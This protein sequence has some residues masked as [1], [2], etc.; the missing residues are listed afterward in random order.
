MTP[1]KRF[2]TMRPRPISYHKP[3]SLDQAIGLLDAKSVVLNGGQ[4]LLATLRMR[5]YNPDALVDIKHVPGL[6]AEV[7]VT[8]QSME[9]GPRVT[10]ENFLKTPDIRERMPILYQAGQ[11]LADAQIRAQ[12]TV[13]GSMCWADPRANYPVAMLACDAVIH[14]QGKGG[15]RTIAADEFFLGFRANSLRQEVVT[16]VTVPG[17]GRLGFSTYREYSRQSND[18]CIVNV[19]VAEIDGKFRVAVGGV[20][21]RP[22]LV[23]E[24]AELLTQKAGSASAAKFM[25]ILDGKGL[26]PVED[27]HGAPEF[28]FNLV[29]EMLAEIAVDVSGGR[30]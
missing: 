26:S 2:L 15:K 3:T 25:A 22:V 21:K 16:K 9:I 10:I 20:E 4:A 18:V 27:G 29:A 6:S 24:A 14:A 30:T 19:A 11:R 1:R 7:K 13:V 23:S 28:R 12:G 17:P 8:D 5:V